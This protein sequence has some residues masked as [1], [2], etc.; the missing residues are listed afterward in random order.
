MPQV[1][2][3][4]ARM[5]YSDLWRSS[6]PAPLGDRLRERVK[7]QTYVISSQLVEAKVNLLRRKALREINR[8]SRM[9]GDD[10]QPEGHVAPALFGGRL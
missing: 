2:S 5:R 8:S 1:K 6:F 10:A 3:S 4:G 9:A 7:T